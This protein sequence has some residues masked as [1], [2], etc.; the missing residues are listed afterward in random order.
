VVEDGE[1]IYGDGVNIAARVEAIAEGGGICISGAVYDHIEN[2]LGFGYEY[3][4]EHSVKNIIKP[5]RIYRVAMELKEAALEESRKEKARPRQWKWVALATVVVLLVGAAAI[6]VWNFWLRGS[7]YYSGFNTEEKIVL[8]LPDKPSIA[9]L[10]FTNLSSDEGQDYFSDGITND[11]ITDLSKFRELFVIASNTVF[12]YKGRRVKVKDVGRELGVRYVLEGSVQMAKKKVRINAQLIEAKT[13]HHIWAERYDRD[14]SD[15][16]AVQDEI[17]Q[18]I[19]TTLPIKIEAAERARVMRKDTKSMEAY[20]YL[21]RGRE[22]NRRIA[23]SANREAQKM[24]QRAID[25]DPQ[26]AS[27]YVGLASSHL[28]LFF[29]GLTEFPAK[30]LEQVEVFAQKALDI[31]ESNAGAHVLLGTAYLHRAQYDLATSELE[32]A[33]ELNPNDASIYRHLGAIELYTSRTDEAIESLKTAIRFDPNIT[34]GTFTDLGLAYYLKGQYEEA[35]RTLQ[36]GVGR[37]PDFAWTFIALAAVYAQSGRS[38]EAERAAETV[39]KLHPF[40]KV[41]SFGTLFRN[42]DDRVRIAEGL[43]K[44]GLK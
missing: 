15:L 10:P 39:L 24:F 16:F 36:R 5:I 35:T 29:F 37:N 2:K 13:G 44:A 14:L 40:F 6:A 31:D 33:L 8:P 12:T 7:T 38:K 28:N 17:I 42:P 21:L 27:A 11:I 32:R 3:L 30:T 18:T 43:R 9:V 22:Y 34:A 41:D 19:V 23:R 1:R 4:G 20:D 25:I 26:Y